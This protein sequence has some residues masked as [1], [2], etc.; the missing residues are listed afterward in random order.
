MK[1]KSGHQWKRISHQTASLV[2]CNDNETQ[3]DSLSSTSVFKMISRDDMDK[4]S[5]EVN[6]ECQMEAMEKSTQTVKQK[7]KN[8]TQRRNS[9]IERGIKS[10]N[11]KKDKKYKRISKTQRKK[12]KIHN[13]PKLL[14]EDTVNSNLG[15]TEAEEIL[16]L[17]KDLGL[18]SIFSDNDTLSFIKKRLLRT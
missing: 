16:S 13:I 11:C 7:R 2:R 15:M 17:G 9:F 1:K 10:R 3:S 12:G 6:E 14:V 8:T 18:D 5:T 4:K